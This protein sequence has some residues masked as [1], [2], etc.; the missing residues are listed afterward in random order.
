MGRRMGR[1]DTARDGGRWTAGSR[2]ASSAV[3]DHS[4]AWR[5][6][7]VG[8][9]TWWGEEQRPEA[10]G[11]GPA[12]R[13]HDDAVQ[14]AGDRGRHDHGRRCCGGS[15]ARS[16]S[17]HRRRWSRSTCP[18]ELGHAGRLRSGVGRCARR[19]ACSGRW[20]PAAARL[21]SPCPAATRS[22]RGGSTCTRPACAELGATTVIEHGYVVAS[23]ARAARRADLAGLPERRRHREHP[24]GRRAGRGHDGDRQRRP[25]AGDRRH[26]RDAHPMGAQIDGVGTS[27]LIERGRRGAAA[28]RAPRHP[29][30]HRRGARGRSPRP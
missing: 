14:R 24:D 8:R 2:L 16:T 13:G 11:G 7:L 25:R 10:D 12:R 9:S 29:G 28:R 20:W 5:A 17:T 1:E 27:T 4:R 18:D 15:A 26:L 21:T 22:A 19:S 23:A 30:P 6:Q 3:V